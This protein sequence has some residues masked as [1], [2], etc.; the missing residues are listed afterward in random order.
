MNNIFNDT[1]DE[2]CEMVANEY[3]ALI[4]YKDLNEAEFQR[5][6]YYL[7]KFEARN[8][9]MAKDYIFRTEATPQGSV[10][11]DPET[12][13]STPPSFATRWSTPPSFPPNSAQ[14]FDY[15]ISP[16]LLYW[17][18]LN[19]FPPRWEK[20]AK[21]YVY[22][23]GQRKLCPYLAVEYRTGKSNEDKRVAFNQITGAMLLC[24]WNRF[25]LRKRALAAQEKDWKQ[26]ENSEIKVYGV[27][28]YAEEYDVW[29]MTPIVNSEGEWQGTTMKLLTDDTLQ[30]VE[31]VQCLCL[32][33]NEIHRWALT[34][35][36]QQIREDVR[37]LESKGG[38]PGK[39][40]LFID[41][42]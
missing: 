32:W 27:R 20:A 9:G 6:S 24:L 15:D 29:V 3:K 19:G 41:P 34:I 5:S 11:P 39:S 28:V 4:S 26:E 22:I 17:L 14:Y 12:L 1:T 30:E 2:Y 16:G 31:G 23:K 33:I 38:L 40:V 42:S 7:F 8:P 21:R 35:H 18:S 10:K 13:W 37:A 36:A 25:Q